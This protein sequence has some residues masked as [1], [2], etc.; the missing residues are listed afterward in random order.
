MEA[1]LS[2]EETEGDT[3]QSHDVLWREASTPGYLSG[4]GA[5]PRGE[6]SSGAPGSY[7]TDQPPIIGRDWLS[8]IKIDWKWVFHI[9]SRTLQQVLDKHEAVF[10]KRL[11]TMKKFKTKLHSKSGATP[12]FFKARP[13]LFALCPKVEALLEKLVQEGVLEVTHSEWGSPIV[14]VPKKTGGVRICGDYKVILNQVLDVDQHPLPKPSD[15]FAAFA[16]GKMFSKL[17]LTRA[18][19]QMEVEEKCQHL[20]TITTH[21]GLYCYR[22]LPFGISLA[23]ALFQRTMEQ[24]L[25]GIPGVVGF[26]DDIE[27]TGATVE[28]HL[29]R[30][31][32]VL[33][34]L[35]EHGLRLQKSK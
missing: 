29:D 35:E 9:K 30:L 27:L 16:G 24:I 17:D 19:H 33:Q 5:A 34:Q 28:E 25:Q 10:E 13:V 3:C 18:Y 14:I 8:K 32:Q 7:V 1:E 4:G 23:P 20:L 12:K 2:Q 31:D 22:R 15:L 11:G 26:M 6:T 21:K